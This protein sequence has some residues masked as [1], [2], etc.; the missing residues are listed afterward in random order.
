MDG[1]FAGTDGKLVNLLLWADA[2]GKDEDGN[3]RWS[4][5]IEWWKNWKATGSRGAMKVL[6]PRQR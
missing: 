3:L 5:Y 2:L 6:P 1:Y 4:T